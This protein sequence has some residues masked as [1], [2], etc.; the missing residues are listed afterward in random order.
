MNDLFDIPIRD[1]DIMDVMGIPFREP[2]AIEPNFGNNREG[3]NLRMETAKWIK[4]HPTTAELFFLFSKQLAGRG[5][6]FGMKAI[7]ERVR[8]E[9]TLEGNHE[10]YKISNDLVAYIARWIIARDKTIEPFLRFKRVRY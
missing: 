7:A 2:R 6:R 8:W 3:K 9:V 4:A 10:D 1:A 5:K